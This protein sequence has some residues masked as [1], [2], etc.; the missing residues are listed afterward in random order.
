MRVHAFSLGAG[1]FAVQQ[2]RSK[3]ALWLMN[4]VSLVGRCAVCN[5]KAP[6]PPVQTG[7]SGDTRAIF[8]IGSAFNLHT[9]AA[10]TCDIHVCARDT[11]ACDASE[12]KTNLK[13][14][15]SQPA[16]VC[17]LIC[18][19][20]NLGSGANKSAHELLLLWWP[21]SSSSSPRCYRIRLRAVCVHF[22]CQRAITAACWV[23]RAAALHHTH[24]L[25]HTRNI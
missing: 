2:A 8:I 20:S 10:T 25:A 22:V 24:T 16:S 4:F 21:S 19:F 9:C 3:G 23:V 7:D 15:H 18:F 5:T 11:A 1:S 6:V 13:S 14:A 12:V 17:V